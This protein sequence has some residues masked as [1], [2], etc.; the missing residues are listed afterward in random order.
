MRCARVNTRAM[1]H[2]IRRAVVIGAGSFGTAVAV[3]LERSGVRTTLLT[4]TQ[5]QASELES[6]RSNKR[7]LE[8]VELPR[9]LRVQG[10]NPEEAQFRRADAIFLAVPTRSLGEA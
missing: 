8:G 2:P 7:Y 3:L 6:E 5:E 4:R 1:R 10:L 9:G